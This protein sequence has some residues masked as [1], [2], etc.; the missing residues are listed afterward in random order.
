MIN[1]PNSKS[2]SVARRFS[3]PCVLPEHQD[4]SWNPSRLFKVQYNQK[5]PWLVNAF[6]ETGNKREEIARECQC[7][8]K[9]LW[10]RKMRRQSTRIQL[11][12]SWLWHLGYVTGHPGLLASETEMNS[13]LTI[14]CQFGMEEQYISVGR[15]NSHMRIKYYMRWADYYLTGLTTYTYQF[16][17]TAQLCRCPFLGCFTIN[18]MYLFLQKCIRKP[19]WL[20]GSR[21]FINFFKEK[22]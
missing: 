19:C 18:F 10:A 22:S 15:T 7:L 16:W 9:M 17:N 8:L 3:Y 12:T 6:C 5:K 13:S 4:P 11:N 20:K 1:I 2:F 14:T 21:S